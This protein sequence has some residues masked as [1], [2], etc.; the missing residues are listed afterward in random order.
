MHERQTL[1]Y[2]LLDNEGRSSKEARKLLKKKRR[3]YFSGLE[4]VIPSRDRIRVWPQSFEESNFSD[5]EIKR[6]LARQGVR[7]S[8]QKVADT[9]TGERRKGLVEA[10][11][12][13]L[14]TTIDKPQLNVDLMEDLISRRRKRPNVKSLRPI[15]KFVERS[16]SL[17]MLNHQPADQEMQRLNR[18]TG[19][20][21]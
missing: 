3:F 7:L 14:K 10:L 5:A 9:R 2:F 21:G 19:L 4:K 15:E 8:S 13:E 11:L 16:G 6:A 20:L 17:I 12:D 18:E 1:V